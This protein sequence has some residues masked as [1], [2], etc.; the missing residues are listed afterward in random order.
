M[1]ATSDTLPLSPDALFFVFRS[2]SKIVNAAGADAG[3][4]PT[5]GA[6]A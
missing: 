5:D 2:K 1:A 3:P 4:V 6:G